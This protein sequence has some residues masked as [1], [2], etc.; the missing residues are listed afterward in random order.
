MTHGFLWRIFL[1][2]PSARRA[3]LA[4]FWGLC[5]IVISIHALREEGDGSTGQCRLGIHISIHA[6]RE[7]GDG[8]ARA[9]LAFPAFISIHALREEGDRPWGRR[10]GFSFISIHAL[11]EEGDRIQSNGYASLE[12]SIHALREEGDSCF[13]SRLCWVRNF[14]PRP[15]RGGR[16]M[17]NP[18]NSYP[19]D[20]YPRPPRGGRLCFRGFVFITQ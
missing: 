18:L 4:L 14:Y 16:R 13:G 6:L 19:P 17:G 9:A 15:P 11:R 5:G 2:T 12:I 7:E 10:V 20:F 3:T 8:A 1:S